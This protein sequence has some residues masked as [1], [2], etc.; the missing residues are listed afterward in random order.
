MI[1]ERKPRQLTFASEGHTLHHCQIQSFD[2][3]YLVFDSRNEDTKIGETA[4]I[5]VLHLSDLSIQTVYRVKNQTPYGP[6]VGA[7]T[8]SPKKNI[9]L[10]IHGIQNSD[11]NKPYGPT[12]RTGVA[13]DLDAP[14]IPIFMDA[15]NVVSPFTPGALRGGTHSHCWHPQGDLISFTYNDYLLEQAT[16]PSA[17]ND[18]RGVGVM[19][20]QEVQVPIGNDGENNSGKMF[21]VLVTQLF[22]NAKHGSD[23]IEKAFDECWLGNAKRIAFQG[24]V[25]DERGEL[26]TEIFMVDLPEDL[27]KASTLPLQGTVTQRPFPPL[28][29]SQ[30]RLT[31]TP[32]GIS[33]FRHWLRSDSTGEFIYFLMEDEKNISQV[34][35]LEVKTNQLTQLSFHNQSIH[36][37]INIS[38]DNKSL[39]YFCNHQIYSLNIKKREVNLIFK[40]DENLELTGIPSFDLLYPERVYFNAYV[41]N[42][43][44]QNYIQIFSL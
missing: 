15:R 17:D 8:F 4:T 44:N 14:E 19:F 42:D 16:D 35:S 39:V 43:L 32:K 6:G 31:F 9:V 26:K 38:S 2:G 41:L 13:V 18:L 34:W 20:P 33:N 24:H 10:F 27:T 1:M 7:A 5:K 36:S 30:K 37:P 11:K 12:R 22:N 40:N 29:T 28:N 25:R 21:S 23:E 3:K